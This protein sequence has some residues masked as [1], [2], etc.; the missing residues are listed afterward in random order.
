M[1]CGVSRALRPSASLTRLT[2]IRAMNGHDVIAMIA[3]RKLDPGTRVAGKTK[4]SKKSAELPAS[5]VPGFSLRR[6]KMA[7][8]S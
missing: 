6:P 8:T 4:D 7:M 3:L 2:P 5:T 1:A